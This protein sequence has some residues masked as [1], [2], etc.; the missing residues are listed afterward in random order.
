MNQ[1]SIKKAIPTILFIAGLV[2]ACGGSNSNAKDIQS[3][4]IQSQSASMQTEHEHAGVR[5]TITNGKVTLH[6]NRD[7]LDGVLL[8]QEVLQELEDR[9]YTVEGLSGA[10]KGV[11]IGDVGQDINPV[12][13]CILE[14]GGIEVLNIGKALVNYDFKT[15]GRMPGYE[16]VSSVTNEGVFDDIGGG[17]SICSYVTLFAIDTKGNKKEIDFCQ[18]L[19]GNWE[20]L[21][22]TE[23]QTECYLLGFTD[24]WKISYRSGYAESEAHEF[25]IGRFWKIEEQDNDETVILTCGYEMMEAGLSE[26][27]GIPPDKT[28]RKGTFKVEASYMDDSIDVT[29]I[30]GL[31][32]YPGKLG[33]KKKFERRRLN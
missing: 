11:F 9:P 32:F 22:N 6:F 14:D 28:V 8:N 17:D 2:M 12:L 26:M 20:Y 29:C 18:L 23:G 21:V 19:S 13:A 5:A 15:S 30:S 1:K 4:D 31:Q 25:F 10:C 27:T 24:D 33:T 3:Q 16:H 7:K